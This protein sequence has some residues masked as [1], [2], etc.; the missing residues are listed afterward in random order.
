MEVNLK[1]VRETFS[2]FYMCI[3]TVY[4]YL[5]YLSKTLLLYNYITADESEKI[6][7]TI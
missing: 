7:E 4:L 1:V 2:R 6:I 3:H 5:F